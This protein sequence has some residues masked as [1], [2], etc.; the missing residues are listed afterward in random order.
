[1]HLGIN[2]SIAMKRWPEPEAWSAFVAEG[3]GLEL[4]Q[5]SFDLLDPWWPAADRA[6]QA[7]RV[8]RAAVATGITIHSAQ[9]GFAGYTYNGLLS[10]DAHLRALAEQWWERAIE[11][12]AAIGAASVGG[13]L[14]ALTVSSANQREERYAELLGTLGR[15]CDRAAA[16]GLEAL[17]V[18][19]TPLAREIPADVSE[20]ERLSRDL[21]GTSVPIRYVLDVGHAMYRPLYGG[22]APLE[23][24]LERLGE[25]IGVLHLQ[26]TDFQGD[27]H[28]GWPDPRGRFDVSRFAEQVR[29]AA[30]EAPVFIEV[31]HPFE[32]DDLQ[33]RRHVVSTVEHCRRELRLPR[34]RQAL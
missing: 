25:D 22:E 17:L 24:W 16:A 8:A 29:A 27:S 21:A 30:V 18:E 1:M 6:L 33:M 28:W 11:I 12:G 4:V 32:L 3:L 23:P 9:V 13:P 14:G 20:A 31:V 5:F 26:N 34:E 10:P 19:P 7:E 15:L 2:L